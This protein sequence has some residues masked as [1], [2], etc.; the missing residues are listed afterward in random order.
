MAANKCARV[1]CGKTVYPMEELK[2]LDQVWH[3]Q[4]FR[5]STCAM[6]LTMK[7]YKGYNKTP[8]CEAHYP[9]AK[10]SV[11]ADTPEMKR[12][13]EN[14]KNQSLIR[15][16]EEY[17]RMRGKKIEVADDPEIQR[18]IKNT[19]IQSNVIYHGELDKKQTMERIRPPLEETATAISSAGGLLSFS[20]VLN[21]TVAAPTIAP[22][23]ASSTTTA[24]GPTVPQAAPTKQTPTKNFVSP[25]SAKMQQTSTLIYSSER[26]GKVT[27]QSRTVGSI[28][29]YDPMNGQWGSIVN[30]NRNMKSPS[31]KTGSNAFSGQA[32]NAA[33]TQTS[34]Q[35]RSGGG[36][37]W[38]VTFKEG[39]L[40]VNCQAVDQGW[41]T[42]TVQRTGKWGMLPANY[43]ERVH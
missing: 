33:L 26:G 27:P 40:I 3:K 15:Y 24:R 8:Y 30:S 28:D 1:E 10:A 14:T 41:M 21:C 7:N 39:D 43:V 22:Q 23:V 32:S 2:C 35:R 5:C 38:V 18:H 16:H 29:N 17:E 31:A 9:K 19:Q 4:C 36:S 12:L 13:Q 34:S 6:V 25:Y 37:G 11:V 42:G 20:H